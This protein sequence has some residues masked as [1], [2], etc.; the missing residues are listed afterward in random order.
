MVEIVWT[1]EAVVWLREIHD[2]IA[3]ESPRAADRVIDGITSRV[4]QLEAFPESV[5]PLNFPN[6]H[7]LRMVLYGHYRIV[8]RYSAGER[9]EIIGFY[10]G[11]LDIVRRLPAGGNPDTVHD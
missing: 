6:A 5:A 7:D 11:A 4:H 10:H 2:H 9:V 3:S 1:L 8:Y